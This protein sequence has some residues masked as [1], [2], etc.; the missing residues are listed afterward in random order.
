MGEGH[1]CCCDNLQPNEDSL[2]ACKSTFFTLKVIFSENPPEDNARNQTNGKGQ[3]ETVDGEPC[4][5]SPWIEDSIFLDGKPVILV[6]DP[7]I[8]LRFSEEALQCL[9][10]ECKTEN[11]EGR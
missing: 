7:A 8:C 6:G 3:N 10:L 11:E 4:V 5:L 2:D 1:V 9:E